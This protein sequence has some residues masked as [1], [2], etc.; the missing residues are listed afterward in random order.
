MRLYGQEHVDRYL[1]TGGEEGHGWQGTH[2]YDE[3]QEK[4][5]REIPVV[6]LKPPLRRSNPS[7]P[8]GRMTLPRH[9]SS[10][11]G[12]VSSAFPCREWAVPG[13]NGRPPARKD[14]RRSSAAR[15]RSSF[16]I[17]MRL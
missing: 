7:S 6:V 12:A 4:T 11:K 14:G 10:Y 1:A 2:A 17:P 9:T 15:C 5:E 13:S 16:E 8:S 3:Y